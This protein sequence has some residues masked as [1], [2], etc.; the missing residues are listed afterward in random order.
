MTALHDR[1][2][3]AC[4]GGGWA[5]D[6]LVRNQTRQH[7][8]L[9]IWVDASHYEGLLDALVDE[10]VDRIFPWPGDRPWNFVL[11]DGHS[12]RVD[13]HVYE[14]LS[15]GRLHY[16]SVRTP[17]IFSDEDLAGEGEIAGASVR[18]ERADF[19]LRNRTGYEPRD[20]DRHDVALLCETLGLDPPDS[21][22][23]V[24]VK[25]IAGQ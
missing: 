8:D 22:R 21:Y 25:R 23:Q 9:D 3:D 15:D 17:F 18:C 2:V 5:V 7:S 16:G 24:G 11:H 6:A 14:L 13:L 10:G 20:T 19:V 4:V 1:G 12:R